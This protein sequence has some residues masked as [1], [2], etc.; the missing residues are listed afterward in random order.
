MKFSNPIDKEIDKPMADHNE[1]LPPTQS[2]NP[3]IFLAS[4]PNAVAF[5]SFVERATKCFETA[6]A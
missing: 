3:N 6:L 5:S 2:Q 4:I 1:Y